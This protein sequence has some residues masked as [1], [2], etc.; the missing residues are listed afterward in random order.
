MRDA[1]VEHIFNCRSIIEKQLH[2]RFDLFHNFIDFNKIFDR[3]WHVDL[4]HFPRGFNI[5]KGLMQVIQN[6][7][8]T[9][10]FQYCSMSRWSTS[11]K[12][13]WASFRDICSHVLFNLFLKKMIQMNF[14]GLFSNPAL[15]WQ[16]YPWGPN[17]N[18]YGAVAMARLSRL[19]TC[20]SISFPTNYWLDT[21]LVDSIVL[22]CC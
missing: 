5:D 6:S 4:W 8:E 19:W 1:T 11:F 15:G 21:S 14:Q 9:H 22:F 16:Q 12:L 2:Y 13:Q 7:T 20:I 3:T 18:C 10:P 17:K